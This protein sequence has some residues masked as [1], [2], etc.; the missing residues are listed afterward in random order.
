MINLIKNAQWFS[1]SDGKILYFT[2]EGPITYDRFCLDLHRFCSLTMTKGAA[3]NVYDPMIELNDASLL[4]F[5]YHMRSIYVEKAQ[6][7]V[8]FFNKEGKAIFL[9]TKDIES[10]LGSEFHDVAAQFHIPQDACFAQ[11]GLRFI[12]DVTA[13]TFGMPFAELYTFE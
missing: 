11:I 8:T 7:L 5:G 3:S 2:N 12:G 10:D 6:L 4:R 13:C 1:Q 9:C